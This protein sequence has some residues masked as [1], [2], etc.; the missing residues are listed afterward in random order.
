MKSLR[1]LAL[2]SLICCLLLGL[3]QPAAA[4]CGFFVSQANTSLFNQ[5]SQ[6]IIARDHYRTI[7]TMANDYQGDIENFAL[8]VPIPVAISEDQVHVGDP[9]I[10]RRLDEFSAPRLVEYIDSDP[11]AVRMGTSF[12]FGINESQLGSAP[13]GS[14]GEL[15]YPSDQTLGVTVEQRFNRGEYNILLLSAK[16]SKGL[17][18]WLQHNGYR[19]PPD[20][21]SVL[22]PYIRQ[23]FKFFVAKAN[24]DEFEQQGFQTLRPLQ[25][26]YESPRFSLPIRLGMLNAQG[27]QDLIV[28]L[29]TPSGRVELTNYRTVE[30]TTATVPEFVEN[31]FDAFYQALL[32]TS[33]DQENREVAFLEYAWDMSQCDPC[34]ADPLTPQE[35]RQA[36]VFWL[37]L[38]PPRP[39][40]P[41]SALPPF[42]ERLMTQQAYITRLHLRYSRDR[43]PEDLTF[44]TT[45]NRRNFQARYPIWRPYRGDL[46]CPAAASYRASVR[47]RQ[48]REIAT[49]AQ[50]TGWDITELH[51]K[52]AWLND[53]PP[54][55]QPSGDAWWRDLFT[56][57]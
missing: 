20:A 18:T 22:R 52:V 53:P 46:N 16:E 28:Y 21:S 56:T 15:A 43:F 24:L 26:A 19:L 13:V 40:Q 30:M 4:F 34:V 49:T 29:L 8:V 41:A 32:Q 51:H 47:D 48:A 11:C 57:E 35:L 25:I 55:P 17:E 42:P 27:D 12:S 3:A 36:G 44:Q 54:P 31:E 37:S 2:L 7:L 39:E 33:Y 38:S 5:A 1:L 14:A 50:L 6:V 10:L 9:A 45:G 23:N